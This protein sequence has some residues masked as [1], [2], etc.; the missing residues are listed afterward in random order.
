[1]LHA[2]MCMSGRGGEASMSELGND[3]RSIRRSVAGPLQNRRTPSDGLERCFAGVQIDIGNLDA[4]ML[5][6]SETRTGVE[7]H[8]EHLRPNPQRHRTY[9]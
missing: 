7:G 2:T 4:W 8:A 6:R 5:Q 3:A 1:L 9:G